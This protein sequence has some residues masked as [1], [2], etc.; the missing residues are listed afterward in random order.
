MTYLP[1]DVRAA[2]S[3]GQ[4]CTWNFPLVKPWLPVTLNTGIDLP[5]TP[6]KVGPNTA[7]VSTSA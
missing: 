2:L 3:S 4:F 7:L 5:G 1:P 6:Q